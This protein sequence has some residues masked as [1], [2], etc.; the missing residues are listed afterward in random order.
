MAKAHGRNTYISVDGTEIKC[1]TSTIERNRDKHDTTLYGADVHDYEPGLGGSTLTLA[2]IYDNTA[3]TGPRAVLRPLYD[4][5]EKVAI[6]RR[7]DGVGTGKPEED[8]TGFVEKYTETNPVA[9]MVTWSCDIQ[10]TTEV[11]ESAQA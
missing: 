1:T 6:V 5:G 2:G 4:S 8:F 7:P 10:I 11:V 9:D 3:V